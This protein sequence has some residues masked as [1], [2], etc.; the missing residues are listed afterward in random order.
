MTESSS[1]QYKQGSLLNQSET[2]I[3]SIGST[4]PLIDPNDSSENWSKRKNHWILF[5]VSFAL[6]LSP[7]T[8]T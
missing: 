7:M 6:V 4:K 5:V 1:L 2:S 3:E 8:I